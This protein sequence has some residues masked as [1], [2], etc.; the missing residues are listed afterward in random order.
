MPIFGIG[1]TFPVSPNVRQKIGMSGWREN[2]PVK[3][4][5]RDSES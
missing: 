3:P 1:V 2:R 4:N 5:K